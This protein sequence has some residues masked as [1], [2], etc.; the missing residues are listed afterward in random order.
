M[1]AEECLCRL[2]RGDND[3]RDEAQAEGHDRPVPCREA[4]EAAVGE[5][6]KHVEVADDG[7]RRRAGWESPAA[8]VT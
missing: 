4:A 3:G 6:A 8:P 7:E 2:R 1:D 5:V